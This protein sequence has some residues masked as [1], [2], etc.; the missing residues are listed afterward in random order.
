MLEKAFS[1]ITDN[2]TL[3]SRKEYQM[4]QYQHLLEK[5]RI[6]QSMSRKKLFR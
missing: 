2:T 4:K 6:R 5:K 1:K 3:W